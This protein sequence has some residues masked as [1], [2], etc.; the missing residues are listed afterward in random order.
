MNRGETIASDCERQTHAQQDDARAD[1][2]TG[3]TGY[4]HGDWYRGSGGSGFWPGW[5]CGFWPGWGCGA[6][7][8]RGRRRRVTPRAR[9]RS[10]W[11]RL[12][13]IGRCRWLL[14]EQGGRAGSH[15]CKRQH[16]EEQRQYGSPYSKTVPSVCFHST[17]SHN[18]F[19]ILQ[20][21]TAS[22]S[23][24]FGWLPPALCRAGGS[25]DYIGIPAAR[26]S[27][28]VGCPGASAARGPQGHRGHRWL[29]PL[30][31]RRPR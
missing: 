4:R 14:S 7:R 10:L 30:L 3:S 16:D 1:R 15:Q 26:A 20:L 27:Q 29:S 11:P 2:S 17:S 12:R 23:T 19:L 9:F 8:R 5:G 31:L 21:R 18:D 6:W 28:R 25:I 13:T 22:N 24:S